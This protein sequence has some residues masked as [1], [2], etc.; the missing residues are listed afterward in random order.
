MT[1]RERSE[2]LQLNYEIEVAPAVLFTYNR[3]QGVSY[4]FVDL[5]VTAKIRRAEEIK[6]QQK[7]FVYK[8]M[9]LRLTKYLFFL[10][11]SSVSLWA[12]IKRKTWSRGFTRYE[13]TVTL[14]MQEK[15]G[16]CK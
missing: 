14:P 8:V 15:C 3:A 1:L 12:N 11:E 2:D 10:D 5:A 13:P 4:R 7:D 16:S 6:K 9:T